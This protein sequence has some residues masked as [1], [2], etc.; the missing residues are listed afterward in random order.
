MKISDIMTR[1]L[2]TADMDDDLEHLRELFTRYRFRHLPIM[3]DDGRLAGIVSDRDVLAAVSPFAGTI[4]ERTADANSLRRRAHQIM[5]RNP[6]T[7]SPDE[8]AENATLMLLHR[9]ISALPVVDDREHLVGIVTMR[10]LMRWL[11]NHAA[12]DPREDAA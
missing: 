9:R 10:D 5:S 1:Q 12:G 4:N 8:T 11:L 6:H 2:V 3:G 7:V